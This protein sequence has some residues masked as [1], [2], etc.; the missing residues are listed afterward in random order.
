MKLYSHSFNQ[1]IIIIQLLTIFVETPT[2]QEKTEASES[3]GKHACV[4]WFV[5]NCIQISPLLD[6]HTGLARAPI[7]SLW[8]V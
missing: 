5:A 7:L 1:I 2:F 8:V 4:L 6:C 3:F